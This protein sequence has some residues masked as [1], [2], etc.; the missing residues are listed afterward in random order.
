MKTS[1]A[2]DLSTPEWDKVFK[3]L[4]FDIG[5]QKCVLLLGPELAH[6]GGRLLREQLRDQ[7]DQQHK[8]D[9]AHFHERDNLFLF[10]N[11]A[12]K[13]EVQRAVSLFYEEAKPD[14][15]VYQKIASLPFALTVSTTP[16][17]FLY[18]AYPKDARAQFAFFN[19]IGQNDEDELDGWERDRPLLYNLCGSYR[20]D[21]S[22]VLDYDDLFRLLKTAMGTPGL[23]KKVRRALGEARSF[24]F[25]GFDF[26]KWYTQLLLR[27]LCEDNTPMQVALSTQYG[28]KDNQIF[29]LKQFNI[30]FIGEGEAFF[31]ELCRRWQEQL[32]EGAADAEKPDKHLVLRL[33]KEGKTGRALEILMK[34]LTEPEDK[35]MAVMVSNWYHKWENDTKAGTEDSRNLDTLYNR[36]VKNINDLATNLPD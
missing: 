32:N 30:K 36:V 34:L 11:K 21:A 16:D 2:P 10:H 9:I 23:P 19:H 28:N 5:R 33:L 6:S 13:S 12:A 14:S 7:L 17:H 35:D 1:T 15:E 3:P 8:E 29:L 27:L 24:F 20:E 26:D 18:Q 22:L 4:L 31:D 25:L